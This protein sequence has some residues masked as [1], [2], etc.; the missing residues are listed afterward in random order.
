MSFDAQRAFG[1]VRDL[2]FPRL[3]SSP[4]ERAAGDYIISKLESF[5]YEPR[6]HTFTYSL[7][8]F[9]TVPRLV[10]VVQASLLLIALRSVS[11]RPGTAAVLSLFL[12]VL[13]VAST[14]WGGLFEKAYDCGKQH[15]SR[16]IFVR[17]AG[18]KP[19]T[20]VILLAHYDSKSQSLPIVA[21][22]VCYS[23]FT[24]GTVA[25]SLAA[26]AVTVA[27]GGTGAGKTL[28]GAGVFLAL[29]AL[30]LLFNRTG[31]L[32]PGALDNASGAGIVLELARSFSDG[33]PPGL[34][35]TFLFT[36]AEEAGLAG[37]VRFMQAHRRHY[38]EKAAYCIAYDGAGAS[39][40]IRVTS[41]YGLPPVRTSRRLA[42]IVLEECTRLGYPCGEVSLP[43]GAGLEQTPVSH[44]GIEVITIHSG[45]LGR[46]V[47]AV[48][49]RRDGPG[50]I[51]PGALDRCGRLGRAVVLALALEQSP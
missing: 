15:E 2:S 48:H 43:V 13:S 19:H 34:D 51:D 14:R 31:N 38:R 17:A 25:L 8:P 16:N 33:V 26:L 7:F 49:S 29:F 11:G 6:T 44:H 18:E 41:G 42:G 21:R 10:L 37:A 12:I 32:S 47:L 24:I 36:G 40:K 5:G 1:H 3:F 50:N 20:D 28:F 22:V 27:G 46:P 9:S 35:L 39:G 30:P 23:L 4:G 45:G